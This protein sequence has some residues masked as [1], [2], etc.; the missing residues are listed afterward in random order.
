MKKRATFTLDRSV[1][2]E[3]DRVSS[4]LKLRK[5]KI[6]ELALLNYFKH[7]DRFLVDKKQRNKKSGKGECLC[8]GIVELWDNEFDA[9]YDDL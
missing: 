2:N 9:I 8:S 5:S 6:V 3:L 4:E 1:V 7:R